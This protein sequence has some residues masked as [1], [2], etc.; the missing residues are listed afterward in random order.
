MIRAI[1]FVL[2]GTVLGGALTWSVCSS[3][4]PT[5]PPPGPLPSPLACD[6]QEMNR[7]KQRVAQLEGEKARVVSPSPAHRPV[8]PVAESQESREGAA[9]GSS[10]DAVG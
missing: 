6:S 8:V 10:Q 4:I 2:V 9:T 1:P 5:A 7:L 3:S